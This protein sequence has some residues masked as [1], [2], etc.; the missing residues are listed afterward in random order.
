MAQV[1]I[2]GVLVLMGAAADYFWFPRA[3]LVVLTA[4]LAVLLTILWVVAVA[5]AVNLVDG[6]DG[7]R[8][9]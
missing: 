4:D 5:N 3:R 8:R 2:A 7:W 6:L 1:F 9:A